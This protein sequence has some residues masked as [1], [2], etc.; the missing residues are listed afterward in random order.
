MI[1][2]IDGNDGVGKTYTIKRL[3]DYFPDIVADIEFRD[4][5]SLTKATDD[6]NFTKEKGVFYIILDCLVSTSQKRIMDR[7]GSLT[8]K[9]HT[10]EDLSHYRERFHILAKE[11]DIPIFLTDSAIGEDYLTEIIFYI[12][13]L[14]D[15]YYCRD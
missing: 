15:G 12:K 11:H 4:R 13:G 5:G 7:G 1:I 8:E 2:E 6:W 3:K 9:Y 10:F 14:K